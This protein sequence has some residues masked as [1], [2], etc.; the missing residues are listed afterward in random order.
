MFGNDRACQLVLYI[1]PECPSICKVLR[2]RAY[3]RWKIKLN[4]I[5]LVYHVRFYDIAASQIPSWSFHNKNNNNLW[6]KCS[7]NFWKSFYAK[8]TTGELKSRITSAVRQFKNSLIFHP[9]VHYGTM[10]EHRETSL[11]YFHWETFEN[12]S[13]IFVRVD[14]WTKD[15]IIL[16]RSRDDWQ[17]LENDYPRFRNFKED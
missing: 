5:L 17:Q 12:L 9:N 2:I 4:W 11:L 10:K 8:R 1:P 15:H 3:Q 13:C 14:R 16:L 7:E 6:N